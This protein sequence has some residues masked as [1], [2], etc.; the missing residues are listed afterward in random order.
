MR[1]FFILILLFPLSLFAQSVQVESNPSWQENFREE[2]SYKKNWISFGENNQLT[3]TSS[4]GDIYIKQGKLYIVLDKV[5]DVH[6]NPSINL[7]NSSKHEFK[8][9]KIEVRAKCP[10]SKGMWPAIWLRPAS[11]IYPIIAGEVDIME[12]ISCFNKYSF[13]PN[14]HIWGKFNG[15]VN[16]HVQYPKPVRN[17]FDISKFHVYSAEWDNEKLIVRVD[18]IEVANWYAKDYPVWPFDYG[19]ELVMDVSYGGWGASCGYDLSKL[20]QA[21]I[22][23]WIKYYKLKTIN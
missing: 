6:K 19:Y 9:G 13:Q 16:N 8:Y 1:F 21:M 4:E 3:S 12:W 17:K 18:G 14:F 23:D 5:F 20:P 7:R 15:K 22:V 2:N 10:I 11:G